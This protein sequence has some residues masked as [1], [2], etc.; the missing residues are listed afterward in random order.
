MSYSAHAVALIGV[1]VDPDKL[2]EA[3][4]DASGEAIN[5]FNEEDNT[6]FDYQ[7]I[8]NSARGELRFI[9]FV[10]DEAGADDHEGACL[11]KDYDTVYIGRLME[12]NLTPLGLWDDDNFGIH[13]FLDESA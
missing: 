13:V 9:A 5:G 11:G 1:K 6:L 8:G 2:L 10:C 3:L 12:K 4:Y 7:L